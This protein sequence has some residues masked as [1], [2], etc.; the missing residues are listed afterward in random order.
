[1]LQRLF[2]G[3]SMEAPEERIATLIQDEIL[4]LAMLGY[5]GAGDL[6][7]SVPVDA[8]ALTA[9]G[10][11]GIIDFSEFWA[12][13]GM[14]HAT[15]S[16]RAGA[17]GAAESASSSDLARMLEGDSGAGDVSQILAPSSGMSKGVMIGLILGLLA[18]AGAVVFFLTQGS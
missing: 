18:I 10:G 17:P 1:M 8:K 5:N 12:N 13:T 6:D 15:G 16:A 14:P 7:G 4:S 11:K 9:N 3:A 2:G